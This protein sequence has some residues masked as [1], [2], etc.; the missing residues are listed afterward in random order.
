M[1]ASMLAYTQIKKRLSIATLYT[2]AILACSGCVLETKSQLQGDSALV[3]SQLHSE[4]RA[5][6]RN[7]PRDYYGHYLNAKA[8]EKTAPQTSQTKNLARVGYGISIKLNE[9]YSPA[10]YR[11]GL[12]ELG[13]RNAKDAVMYFLH[14]ANYE[15]FESKYFY[16]LAYASLLSGYRDLSWTSLRKATALS[17]PK[18]ISELSTAALVSAFAGQKAQS[19]IFEESF[20]RIAHQRQYSL[21]KN[22]LK[23][24]YHLTQRAENSCCEFSEKIQIAAFGESAGVLDKIIELN[25]TYN[26]HR[27]AE[28]PYLTGGASNS[29]VTGGAVPA[30]VVKRNS[31]QKAGSNSPQI[32]K[33][34]IDT[35]F[36]KKK[37]GIADLI[38]LQVQSENSTTRGLN[39]LDSLSI[40]FS[41]DILSAN[42][43]RNTS[44]GDTPSNSI[45]RNLASSLA[46]N[47]ASVTYSL[48]LANDSK[49]HSKI[50][51]RPSLVV[52]DGEKSNIFSGVE[53][54]IVTDG[55][56]NSQSLTKKIGLKLTVV[57]HFIDNHSAQLD[58]VSELSSITPGA[59]GGT[60]RQQLQTSSSQTNVSAIMKFGQTLLIAGGSS[61]GESSSSS[62]TPVM[63]D[64]L[65]TK[66]LFNK[67][68]TSQRM[69]SYVALLTFR[70]QTP[71][72][73]VAKKIGIEQKNRIKKTILAL[74]PNF[75]RS[76]LG[77]TLDY[78]SSRS[79][80]YL[81][82]K[83]QE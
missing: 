20:K 72:M 40:N 42:W 71:S 4:A 12:L 33:K 15:R 65:I 23:R 22:D 75:K 82:T 44:W 2:L 45:T 78:L 74:F 3:T 8:Y 11:L 9:K 38:I 48:N 17:A 80:I 50:V 52:V 30:P 35:K 68:T 18:T 46:L 24:I 36:K 69:F 21:L 58:V 73:N 13:D 83:F 70:E 34:A 26:L 29:Y 31:I 6:L 16:A 51:A 10:S 14:A 37:M 47:V 43:A 25:K 62:K 41:G 5:L 67:K 7:N 77:D 1:D 55:Q 63:G 59:T 61:R 32:E 66:P 19:K 54:T 79:N 60:F 27:V 39:L 56:L 28:N 81:E 49:T 57:P 53:L 64:F 76:S